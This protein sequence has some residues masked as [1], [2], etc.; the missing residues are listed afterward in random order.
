MS[1]KAIE[2]YSS[3]YIELQQKNGVKFYK[4]PDVILKKQLEIWSDIIAK[5]GSAD[6]TFK[7]V[8]DS[9]RAF[10]Q[11]AGRWQ[12]DTLVDTKMAYNHFFAKARGAP[13]K[14]PAKGGKTT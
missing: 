8:L 14:A 13:A 6:P 1:W 9:Q 2:R 3:D 12:N 4:T 5:K 7:K 10:A 11:R